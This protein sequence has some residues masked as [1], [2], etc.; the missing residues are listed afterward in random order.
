MPL[1]RRCSKLP[2]D[3]QCNDAR[4]GDR[5]GEQHWL[6]ADQA[7]VPDAVAGGVRR[8]RHRRAAD[9]RRAERAVQSSRQRLS[10]CR[11][12]Q[13]RAS[14]AA[15]D[16]QRGVRRG[17][18]RAGQDRRRG[19]AAELAPG[20]RRAGVHTEGQRRQPPGVRRRLRRHRR[21]APR[22]RRQDQRGS[23]AAGDRRRSSL[24]RRKLPAVPRRGERCRTGDPR[25]ATTT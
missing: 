8:R 12:C 20:R 4:P 14:G 6:V 9:L 2:G 17:V 21:G 18:L 25:P 15:A 16:E 23:L 5:D 1:H 3:I 11:R 19:G 7:G 13:G 22:A 24:L 10:R